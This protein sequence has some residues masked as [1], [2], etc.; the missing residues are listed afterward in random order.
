MTPATEPPP[1][2]DPL[3]PRRG[4][5]PVA[6]MLLRVV[7]MLVAWIVLVVLAG[8]LFDQ[9]AEYSPTLLGRATLHA[10]AYVGGS[11]ALVWLFCRFLDRRRFAAMRLSRRGAGRHLVLGLVVG[12]AMLGL[13][14]L[15]QVLA[16]YV[17]VTAVRWDTLGLGA[18]LAA[19]LIVVLTEGAAGFCEE[20]VFRGYVLQNVGE[21]VAVWIS[22]LPVT[23]VFALLH[24][25]NSGFSAAWVLTILIFGAFLVSTRLLTGSL[26]FAIGWHAAWNIT[27]YGILGLGNVGDPPEYRYA[28]LDVTQTG[29]VLMVGEGQS[30]EGGLIITAVM[31]VAFLALLR[32][33]AVRTALR[34]RLD[35]AGDPEASRSARSVATPAP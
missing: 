14:F 30:I 22:V 33:K 31:T 19:V 24:V 16:G 9:E 13:I 8:S 32:V 20:L 2:H 28:L 35:R 10:A 7:L 15:V 23:L 5:V 27:Q 26:W 29:P 11:L 25:E 18:A 12:A 34:S 6:L 17:D 3:T 4:P 1:G 21:Q